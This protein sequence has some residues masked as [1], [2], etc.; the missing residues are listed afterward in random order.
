MKK[1]LR[2][3]LAT[4]CVCALL[5]AGFILAVN[6]YVQSAAVQNRI[7]QTLGAALGM[8]LEMFRATFSPWGGFRIDQ[9]RVASDVPGASADFLRA[10]F[11][12]VR[13]EFI[14]LLR[15][16]VVLKRIALDAPHVVLQQT[17]GGAFHLPALARKPATSPST[18]SPARPAAEVSSITL[19][20]YDLDIRKWLLRDGNLLLLDPAGKEILR[21]ES[22]RSALTAQTAPGTFS[23][24]LAIKRAVI[25]NRWEATGI[26]ASVK[27]DQQKVHIDKLRGDLAEGRIEG[28][29]NADGAAPGRPYNY[30]LRLNKGQLEKF[31]PPD[32]DLA[33]ELTGLIHSRL[34]YSGSAANPATN[35]GHAEL[36]ISRS[37]ITQLPILSLLSQLLRGENVGKLSIE[38]VEIKADIAGSQI[39]ITPSII[40]ASLAKVTFAGPLDGQ[41]NLNLK[42][43]LSIE[44]ALFKKLPTEMRENFSADPAM[45]THDLEFSITGPLEAPHTDLLNRLIGEKLRK[46]FHRFLGGMN[47][48]EDSPAPTASPK[49]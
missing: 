25:F 40:E 18:P 8:P 43:R 21:L 28:E 35:I 15:G 44:E 49:K 3:L 29:L 45:G 6:L 19:P 4:L 37:K 31:C 47:S 2:P 7:R 11:L 33:G 32:S 9:I 10:E 26:E 39:Q 34:E 13:C 17:A 20:S 30:W 27:I 42:S 22:I 16:H 24:D 41:R 12:E 14:P 36:K 38:K 5:F 23:G 48:A 1:H 46:K